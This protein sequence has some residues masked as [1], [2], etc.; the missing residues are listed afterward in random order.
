MNFFFLEEHWLIQSPL[1]VTAEI[2]DFVEN[3]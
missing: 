3:R 1:K 2:L